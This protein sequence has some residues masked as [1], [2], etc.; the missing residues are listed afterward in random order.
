[1]R[2]ETANFNNLSEGVTSAS[3]GGRDDDVAEGGVGAGSHQC[4]F[5]SG[6]A[7]RDQVTEGGSF[8]ASDSI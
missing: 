6:C 7:S 5:L 1:M 8:T 3:R 4:P 2:W